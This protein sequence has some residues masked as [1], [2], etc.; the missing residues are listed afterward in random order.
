MLSITKYLFLSHKDCYILKDEKS[1]ITYRKTHIVLHYFQVHYF[2][3]S[4]YNEEKV[5]AASDPKLS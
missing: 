3:V 4:R 2:Q 1:Y 5:L